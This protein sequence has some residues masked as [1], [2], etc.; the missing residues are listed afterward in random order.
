MTTRSAV[1][2]RSFRKKYP[3]AVK[4]EGAW[5]W[6]A[7]GKRYFDLSGSAAVN[8]I[9]HGDS[10]IAK[11]M[12]AQ[13]GALEFV[14]SSQFTSQI[15]EEFAA[16]VLHFAGPAFEGGGAFFTCGGSEAVE[17]ALKLARQYQV[18]VGQTQRTRFLSEPGVSRSDTGAMAV[19][20][21]RKRREIYLP[22]FLD[23]QKVNTPYCYRCLYGC[24]D[25]AKKYA[26]E[27]TA[28]LE[29]NGNEIAGFIFEPVSGA[30]LGAAVPPDGYLER[31][32]KR[33]VLAEYWW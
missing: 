24:A 25:C 22:L 9:G 4:G 13:A 14:H 3:V 16:E 30:T 7:D 6:D 33:A 15:A 31:S 19:S 1:L 20:G 11:A 23:S 18:E 27:V 21:N 8:F 29:A 10:A 32:Q 17:T 28:A 2:P 5:I 12:S 26:G